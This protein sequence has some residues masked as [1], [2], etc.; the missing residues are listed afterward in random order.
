MRQRLW[1]AILPLMGPL[2][3]R[4]TIDAS[5]CHGKPCLRGMRYPVEMLLDLLSSGMSHE[6]ILADYQDLERDDLLAAIAYGAQLARSRRLE[7]A[8]S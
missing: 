5:V 7:A 8:G 1:C 2:L 4:I 6:E 3:S